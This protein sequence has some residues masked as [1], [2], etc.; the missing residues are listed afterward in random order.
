MP[1]SPPELADQEK[2]VLHVLGFLF[3]RMGQYARAKRLFSA[4]LAL[5]PNDYYARCALAEACIHLQDGETALHALLGLTP[6][7]PVPGG[8]TTLYLLR[9]KSYALVGDTD[10][11]REALAAFWALQKNKGSTP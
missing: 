4:L 9:A 5:S 2:S 3:L 1:I 7:T 6:E 8:P 10:A 11:A